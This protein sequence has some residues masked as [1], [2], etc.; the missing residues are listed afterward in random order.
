MNIIATDEKG[1]TFI[2]LLEI[3][4]ED[5]GTIVSLGFP[6]EWYL[7]DIKT[8][9]IAGADKMWVDIGGRNHKGSPVYVSHRELIEAVEALQEAK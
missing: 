4:P 1:N 6:C 9:P 8:P 2:K 5:S 3:R 7:E